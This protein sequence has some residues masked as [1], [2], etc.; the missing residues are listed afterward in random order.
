MEKIIFDGKWTNYL[1]WKQSSH[2]MITFD[3]GNT[4][5]HLRTAHLGDYIYVFVDPVSDLTLD[6]LKPYCLI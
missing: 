5:I 2:N 1:E 3:N 4:I 6:S